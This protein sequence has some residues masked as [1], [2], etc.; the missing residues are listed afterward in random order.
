MVEMVDT[1]DLKSAVRKS[2]PVRLRLA[3]PNKAS[4]QACDCGHIKGTTMQLLQPFNAAQFDPTQGGT[5]GFPIGKHK[6]IAVASEVK[7]TKDGNSGMVVY[8]AK[9]IEGEYTGLIGAFRF[10]LYSTSQQAV[11]IA[12]KQFSA[13]CHC[14]GVLNVNDTSQ[15]HNIPF[16][17]E[18]AMQKGEDAVKKGYTEV[19]KFYDVNGN[20][21][22]QAGGGQQQ[23]QN[24]GFGNQQQQPQ[25]QGGG[26]GQQPQQQGGFGVANNVPISQ[27]QQQQNPAFGPQQG[28]QNQNQQQGT[29][30][31]GQSWAQNVGGQQQGNQTNG[32]QT[33]QQN[34][35]AGGWGQQR[36]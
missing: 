15:T 24:T 33:A 25:N 10:N 13:F 17:V 3:A 6:V 7:P 31:S 9:I 19:K 16:I 22:G 21:P 29:N 2:V 34:P 36:T 12:H 35:A 18:V 28:N 32:G 5:G 1:A 11:E 30:S 27:G 4:P 26:F 23:Q 8:E 14:V 20:E